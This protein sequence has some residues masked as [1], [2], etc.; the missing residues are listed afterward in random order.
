MLSNS[1]KWPRSAACE[2]MCCVACCCSIRH[3]FLFYDVPETRKGN[4]DM[5][6]VNEQSRALDTRR[7]SHLGY[8]FTAR[9]GALF[10]HMYVAV[11]G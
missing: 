6:I 8:Y 7:M 10:M 3:R 4:K 11:I 1:S 2:G 9:E 5:Q